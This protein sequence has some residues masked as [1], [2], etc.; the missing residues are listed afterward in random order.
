MHFWIHAIS[1]VLYFASSEKFRDLYIPIDQVPI[2]DG[3]IFQCAVHLAFSHEIE[4][5][6]LFFNPMFAFSLPFSLPFKCQV[7]KTFCERTE[8]KINI[9]ALC[10]NYLGKFPSNT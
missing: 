6:L 5:C 7:A 9:F 3:G 10:L 1:L 8:K 2:L 4:H